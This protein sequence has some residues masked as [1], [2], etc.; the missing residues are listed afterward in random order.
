MFFCGDVP[1]KHQPMVKPEISRSLKILTLQGMGA[2]ATISH[3]YTPGKSPHHHHHHMHRH[4]SQHLR[5]KEKNR[6][7]CQNPAKTPTTSPTAAAAEAVKKVTIFFCFVFVEQLL[8]A[9]D[10]FTC[11]CN[12]N[13]EKFHGCQSCFRRNKTRVLVERGVHVA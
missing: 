1:E 11:G 2:A 9:G 7:N 5:Q 12:V 4:N 10:L 3:F 13:F 6:W 8:L